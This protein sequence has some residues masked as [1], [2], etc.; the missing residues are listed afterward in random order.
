M[1]EMK[2]TRD[3][4]LETLTKIGCQYELA[5]EGDDI[6]FGYQGEYF[7][8]RASNEN[9]YIQIYDTHWG[10]VE[11]YD[12]EE[13]TRLKKVINESNI[14]NSVTTVYTV[15]EAG[16][17]VDVH[18]KSTIL[19]ISTIPEIDDYLKLELNEFFRVHQYVKLE[20]AKLRDKEN[21]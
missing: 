14:N 9:R 13:F 10:H 6:N 17:N 18:S 5:E 1:E 12:V 11:L 4:F 16:N 2:R 21:A 20:L 3:L 19:F 7:V 15:D 8:V